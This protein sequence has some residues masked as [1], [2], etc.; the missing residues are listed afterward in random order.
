ME[1]SSD[2]GARVEGVLARLTALFLPLAG[3]GV[4]CV[5]IVYGFGVAA[6]VIGAASLGAPLIAAIL[7]RRE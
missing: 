6:A 1:R 7:K 5:A 2:D 4:A 3:L